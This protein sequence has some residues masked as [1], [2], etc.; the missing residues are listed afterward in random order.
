VAAFRT[1]GKDV[2]IPLLVAGVLATGAIAWTMSRGGHTT[3]TVLRPTQFD[4]A[5]YTV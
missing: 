5:H 1:L 4:T 2:L 3:R